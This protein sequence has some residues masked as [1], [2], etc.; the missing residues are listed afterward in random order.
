MNSAHKLDI[1]YARKVLEHL[2]AHPEEH[3]QA[4]IGQRNR[5]GTTACIAGTAVLMDSASTVT[6]GSDGH[7]NIVQVD[8]E[9]AEVASKRA[10]KLLGLDEDDAHH[11]FF[12]ETSMDNDAALALLADY[13]AQAE[14]AQAGL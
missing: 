9:G 14:T 12:D 3:E 5:C 13:I 1:P 2:I 6:W 7:M 10:Q 4:H 11:L 8:G